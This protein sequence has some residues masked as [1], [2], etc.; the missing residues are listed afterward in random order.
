MEDG[1]EVVRWRDVQVGDFVKVTNR[2]F[3]PAD[4]LV[5][6]TSE[7]LGM[8]YIETSNLDGE[9]NLKIHQAH[10]ELAELGLNRDK[11]LGVHVAVEC[12]APNNSLYTFNG[13]MVMFDKDGERLPLGPK[14]VL[15]RGAMLRNTAWAVGI[16]LYTGHEAKVMLNANATR[17][18]ASSVEKRINLQIFLIFCLQIFLCLFS[19]VG[20]GLWAD[21]PGRRHRY[22]MEDSNTVKEAAVSFFTFLILYNNLI[23]ISLYVS[24]ELV[25]FIQ[26][27]LINS[28]VEMY[29]PPS[30]TPAKARTSNLNEE[31]GQIEYIFSDKTGTLTQN[32][33]EFRKCTVGGVA[34]GT[35]VDIPASDRAG[36]G[37]PVNFN[38]T[39]H[40]F[41]EHLSGKGLRDPMPRTTAENTA[42]PVTASASNQLP[43]AA[44]PELLRMF[45]VSLSVCHTVIPEED[46]DDPTKVI[47]Q[48]SSPDEAALVWAGKHFGH[49]FRARTPKSIIVAVN[50]KDQTYQILNVLEFNSTRK[51]MSIICRTPDGRLLL[52]CKGA[53]SVIYER[54]APGADPARKAMEATTLEHLE[55]FAS[56]GLRTL[57][58]AY[59][60]LDE[61][62][63]ERW[64]ATFTT[65][66]A[67]L[68]G[69]ADKL[70]DCAEVIER[71]MLLIGATAIEDKL[72]V[73]V[74]D[75]IATLMR[76]GI[77]VWVLTGDKQETAINIGFSAK[78]L[79]GQMELMTLNSEDPDAVAAALK[80]YLASSSPVPGEPPRDPRTL[81]TII[82]GATL[83]LVLKDEALAQGFLKLACRCLA[84]ICCRVSPLQKSQVVMLV[85]NSLN[86]VTLAIGDGANDVSMIQAAHVGVGISGQ[87]G[88]QAARSADYSIAQF[89]FLLRLLLVHGRWSYRR[90]SKLIIYSFYKN[91]ALYLT[92][93]WYIFLNGYSG[94]TIYDGWTIALFNVFFANFPMLVF[95]VIDQDVS[96]E[97]S[98]AHPQLYALGQRSHYFNTKVF[99]LSNLT[100][101]AHSLAI[102]FLCFGPFW[103]SGVFQGGQ[104]VGLF[105][106]GVVMFTVVVVVANLKMALEFNN[107]TK[108]SA[109]SLLASL[110]LLIVFY[111]PYHVISASGIDLGNDMY[112]IIYRLFSNGPFY[113]TIILVPVVVLMRD[114]LWK[115]YQ[116]NFDPLP[117]HIVQ[118]IERRRG[119]PAL[120]A[121]TQEYVAMIEAPSSAPVPLIA[122]TMTAGGGAS[123]RASGTDGESPSDGV[124]PSPGTRKRIKSMAL[125]IVASKR[126]ENRGYSFSSAEGE[127]GMITNDDLF[128]TRDPT[129]TRVITE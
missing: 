112:W 8:C 74:P 93:F 46:R 54:L 60:Y 120:V 76:G 79:T 1:W 124:G 42:E 75:A 84:V 40:R 122:V 34:Y 70:A 94:Q 107:W 119:I 73:G 90:V 14:Q 78:L 110:A 103:Q 72:Q 87:E 89:R 118:E 116:R 85:R 67:S 47:Y 65:A 51:R 25:K 31:L 111:L 29:D 68:V 27:S 52:L 69:R 4:L 48:A 97:A 117:Y 64:N 21:S 30:D 81:A 98:L 108:A 17:S 19:A 77:K 114:Y 13:A 37:L 61:A 83:R 121:A 39:D 104:D 91:I 38:F 23:P 28:D 102:F 113:F 100:A 62:E 2:S 71:E 95:A 9:T 45:L 49:A 86:C 59:K 125:G 106:V 3:I 18:K 58:L 35:D 66:A 11:I 63:Y 26:A 126:F 123:P 6:T 96:A 101:V 16:A 7:P 22:L 41:L 12:D 5:V 129:F 88:L 50:G 127:E 15:L 99:W 115:A 109:L 128:I 82:D 55:V 36:M 43:V 53:D 44:D 57:C 20:R 80:G 24:L 32:L 10:P 56:V 105:G 33:M 92:Q